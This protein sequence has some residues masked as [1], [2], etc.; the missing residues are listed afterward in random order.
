MRNIFLSLACL[1]RD[2]KY[3]QLLGILNSLT[4]MVESF[5]ID[6]G[7]GSA[8]SSCQQQSTLHSTQS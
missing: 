6:I 7:H 4:G 8:R 3:C 1:V 5:C 2:K